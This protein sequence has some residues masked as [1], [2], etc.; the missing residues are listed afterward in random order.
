MTQLKGAFGYMVAANRNDGYTYCFGKGKSET[1]VSGPQTAVPLGT[2][3]AITGSVLDM[4]PAQ[5]GT[6][7]VSVESMETQMEYLHMQMPIDGVAHDQTITGVPVTLTAIDS[8]GF[9]YNIGTVTTS[10]YHGTFGKSWTPPK[11][12]TF[13]IVASFEGD[14]S[15]GSSSASTY[16]VVGPAPSSGQQQETEPPS[17]PTSSEPTTEPATTEEP[18]TSAEPTTEHPSGEAPFPT[19]EVIIVAAVAVAAVIGIGAYWAFRK[20]K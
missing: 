7:C 11:Q 20:F 4:S 16:V 10:G 15:Y 12:D 13:E 6:P 3:M 19:T 14:E 2:A 18:P 5:P 9:S 17:E 1:T 8:D